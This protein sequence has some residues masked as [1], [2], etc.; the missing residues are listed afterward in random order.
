MFH[1]QWQIFKI[2]PEMKQLFWASIDGDRVFYFDPFTMR[3]ADNGILSS[4]CAVDSERI[5]KKTV[6]G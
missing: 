5:I 2:S 1:H 4:I 3:D 6:S